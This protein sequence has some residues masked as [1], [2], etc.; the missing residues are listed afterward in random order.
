[1]KRLLALGLCWLLLSAASFSIQEARQFRTIVVASGAFSA[2]TTGPMP[3]GN[4]VWWQGEDGNP[5][6]RVTARLAGVDSLVVFPLVSDAP[7]A[8]ERAAS[9]VIHRGEILEQVFP[10]RK[11]LKVVLVKWTDDPCRLSLSFETH[12]QHGDAGPC[13]RLREP[14]LATAWPTLRIDDGPVPVRRSP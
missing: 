9:F 4:K 7:P 8:W 6:F 13:I 11:F 5:V 10:S 3:T 14:T 12:G 2:D 1:M